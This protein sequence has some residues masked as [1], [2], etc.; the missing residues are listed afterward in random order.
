MI[1]LIGIKQ[2]RPPRDS[3]GPPSRDSS[4][5]LISVQ[6]SSR[7]STISRTTHI[8]HPRSSTFTCSLVHCNFPSSSRI[9]TQSLRQFRSSKPGNRTQYS[10][11]VPSNGHPLVAL[12]PRVH[13]VGTPEEWG[14]ERSRLICSVEVAVSVLAACPLSRCNKCQTNRGSFIEKIG[15]K[16]CQTALMGNLEHTNSTCDGE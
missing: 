1:K 12:Q 15:P 10:W 3:P 6:T 8:L 2:Q 5:N 11:I 9:F 7:V 4:F 16:A 13:T 14:D